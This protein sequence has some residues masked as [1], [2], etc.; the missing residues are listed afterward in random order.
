M[1]ELL[2]SLVRR[3]L[4]NSVSCTFRPFQRHSIEERK[5]S[6]TSHWSQTVS[7]FFLANWRTLPTS[8]SNAID[9]AEAVH[10]TWP[11]N[12]F[13]TPGIGLET[14]NGHF[15]M[16]ARQ[17]KANDRHPTRSPRTS[18]RRSSNGSV[19]HHSDTRDR[20]HIPYRACIDRI[21][22]Q[23]IGTRLNRWRRT[24]AEYPGETQMGCLFHRSPVIRKYLSQ[25]Q[26]SHW[27][28]LRVALFELPG[29]EKDEL[30]AFLLLHQFQDLPIL[31]AGI[32][33]SRLLVIRPLHRVGDESRQN[34]IGDLK[35][36]LHRRR[37]IDVAIHQHMRTKKAQ[38]CIRQRSVRFTLEQRTVISLT[39]REREKHTFFGTPSGTWSRGNSRQKLVESASLKFPSRTESISRREYSQRI[40]V[41]MSP[42][43]E[44]ISKSH[45][46]F[47]VRCHV[48]WAGKGHNET[49]IVKLGNRA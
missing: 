35:G 26:I 1:N 33:H 46:S 22:E 14:S 23:R 24:V 45:F 42:L 16:T 40:E 9:Q 3:K 19:A 29:G 36:D 10:F 31:G 6:L 7:P 44:T 8:N 47:S 4:L 38:R 41:L 18:H 30:L 2:C 28:F 34:S 12:W 11:L 17:S 43:N 15:R 49:I 48:R 25:D 5:C 37:G 20:V 13:F 39:E 32:Q 21:G 27:G